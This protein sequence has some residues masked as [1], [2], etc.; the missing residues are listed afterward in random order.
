MMLLIARRKE[1]SCVEESRRRTK[2][3]LRKRGDDHPLAMTPRTEERTTP[4]IT[5]SGFICVCYTRGEHHAI[6]SQHPIPSSSSMPKPI[7]TRH[8][9]RHVYAS[10]SN[11]EQNT[12]HTYQ[13]H[14]QHQTTSKKPSN[15]ML[16]SYRLPPKTPQDL[17]S[18]SERTQ[19]QH[20][21]H[22]NTPPPKQHSQTPSYPS[23]SSSAS[24][25]PLLPNSS[26]R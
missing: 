15:T 17:P 11:L 16:K 3:K 19:S 26:S 1:E 2:K 20:Q 6:L 12:E 18:H 13:H 8:H 24:R 5:M 10:T 23:P 4:M 9:H 14:T 22:N 7:W 25:S 21:S